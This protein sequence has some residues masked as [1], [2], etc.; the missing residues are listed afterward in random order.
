M[1]LFLS[2]SVFVQ[3]VELG[4]LNRAAEKLRL[5]PTM[6]GK[7]LKLLENNLKTQLLNRTTRRISLTASGGEYYHHCKKVLELVDEGEERLRNDQLIPS[8][9]LTISCPEILGKKRILP[10]SLNYMDRFPATHIHLSLTDR[11]VD[12]M[13]EDIDIAIRIGE[14]PDSTD[15]IARPLTDYELVACASAS[16]LEQFGTPEK[17]E[18]LFK[19]QCISLNGSILDQWQTTSFKENIKNS[20]LT[21]DSSEVIKQ[22][23]ISGMGII[24]QAKMFLED[25]INTG[26]LV[27]I[28]ENYPLPARKL[29][30]LYL[31]KKYSSARVNFMLEALQEAFPLKK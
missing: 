11:L 29:N 5:S 27:P 23:A 4:S 3:I 28:L 31:R 19:H 17:P 20:R 10:F 13:R 24:I 25:A 26:L 16:Y 2:M 15:I 21:S 6:V 9:Q 1:N 8:G 14:P 7:H 18:D 12:I 30:A 22:G